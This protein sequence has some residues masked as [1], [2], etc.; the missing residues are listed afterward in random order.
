MG[1]GHSSYDRKAPAGQAPV[2]P[3]VARKAAINVTCSVPAD[4]LLETLRALGIDI[5]ARPPRTGKA[6]RR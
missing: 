1:T 2:D 4:E 6:R 3:A 5:L